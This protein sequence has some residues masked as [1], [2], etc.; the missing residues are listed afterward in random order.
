KY[1]RYLSHKN[2]NW[3]KPSYSRA[4]SRGRITFLKK[5]TMKKIITPLLLLT[6]CLNA[7]AQYLI[8]T[9]AGNGVWGFSGDGGPATS[10]RLGGPTGIAVDTQGNIYIADQST[11]RI[12]KVTSS[13]GFISTIA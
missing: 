4:K 7:Q 10:A 11:Q 9:A 13:T 12:R 1:K 8:T 2:K 3:C 6:F 5:N